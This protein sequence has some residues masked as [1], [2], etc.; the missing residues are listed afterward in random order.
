MVLSKYLFLF[1]NIKRNAINI[2]LMCHF[3]MMNKI[4][5]NF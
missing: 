3:Y 2:Y 5:L 1:T 4:L